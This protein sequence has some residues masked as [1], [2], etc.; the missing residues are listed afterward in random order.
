M[1]KKALVAIGVAALAVGAGA[2]LGAIGTGSTINLCYAKSN[3]TLRV[4]AASSRCR[5][6]ET[7]LTWT[8]SAPGPKGDTGPQ[9]PKG[10]PGPAGPAGPVGAKG[11]AGS[12]GPAGAKGDTGAQGA[13]GPKGEPGA[14][15]LQGPPGAVGPQ[16]PTGLQGPAGPQGATGPS[17]F[18]AP[19][20]VANQGDAAP[21][22]EKNVYV[23]CPYP[24]HAISGGYSVPSSFTVYLSVPGPDLK[25]WTIQGH[26]NDSVN[27]ASV[28]VYAICA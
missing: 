26:N 9:G 11:D 24:K 14:A 27:G 22:G 5:R 1:K 21:S 18:A 7:A 16:G 6:H 15:G 19:E 23:A 25:G 20:V 13:E 2:A 4:I 3:G 17:G 28:G 12:A 8:Q 10:D